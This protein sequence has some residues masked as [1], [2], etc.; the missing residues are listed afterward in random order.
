MPFEIYLVAK[1]KDAKE[2]KLKVNLLLHCAGPEAIEEYSHFVFTNEV[3][4]SSHCHA[5]M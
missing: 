4:K 1:G 3:L 2:D 5:S